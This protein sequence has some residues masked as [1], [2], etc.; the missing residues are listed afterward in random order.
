MHRQDAVPTGVC[1]PLP[2]PPVRA[3]QPALLQGSHAARVH[4]YVLAQ[5]KGKLRSIVP[6]HVF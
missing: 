5:L 2:L 6:I 3:L 1:D 4:A